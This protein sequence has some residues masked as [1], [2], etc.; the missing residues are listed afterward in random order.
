[1]AV[2]AGLCRITVKAPK[3]RLDISLPGDVPF[4]DMLPTLLQY[5]GTDLAEDGS[6]QGGWVLSRLG[7]DVLDSSRTATQLELRD[8][9]ILYLT[10]RSQVAPDYVY[11]DAVDAVANATVDRG[12]KW[13][14]SHT[15][16]YSVGLGIAALAGGLLALLFSGATLAA[17]AVGL[18]LGMLLLVLA[19]V[20]S[21]AVGDSMVG[22]ACGL[23]GA[24]YGTVGGLL[25]LAPSEGGLTALN[26]VIGATAMVLFVL[27]A[28]MAVGDAA[29]VFVGAGIV[30]F[31]F[32]IGS[33]AGVLFGGVTAAGGA[34][35][36][37]A[38]LVLALP[39]L[40]M[41]AY[42]L[43]KLPMPT[44]PS[45]P[46]DLKTDA[47]TVD[48]VKVRRGADT[49]DRF[50]AG[51]LGG[52]AATGL[53]VL[54]FV[55]LGGGMPGVL[56]GLV[57]SLVLLT[58]SRVFSGWLQ[59]TPLLLTGAVGLALVALATFTAS[60]VLLR[61]VGVLVGLLVVAGISL[62]YG[63]SVAG[64]RISPVWG[65]TLDIFEILLILAV[66]PLAAWVWG[67]YGWIM[68]IKG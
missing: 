66:V 3:S 17:G 51:L 49:A 9:E 53:G 46:A 8:G 34:A 25:L 5:A 45:G 40:P 11:D 23:V 59:R 28:A 43:A 4:A 26:A 29:P 2:T 67:A 7:G 44:V 41:N 61:L 10:P 19:A 50:L 56:L 39:S 62:V 68:S 18:G 60:S 24:A 12:G 20:M 55:V 31:L 64:K 32:L 22:A 13:R 38:I 65:R 21:R 14:L 1:M 48:G 37:A 52:V 15:R 63:L 35:I 16:R 6:S 42:R 57:M 54:G 27:L 33:L 30:A 58:Q 47:E 36:V